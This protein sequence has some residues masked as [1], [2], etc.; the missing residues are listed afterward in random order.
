MAAHE[1]AILA[2]F[3]RLC[4][5]KGLLQVCDDVKDGDRADGIADET[6]LR[7]FL[8]ARRMDLPSALGQFEEAIQFRREKDALRV[9]DRISVDDFEHTRKLVGNPEICSLCRD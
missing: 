1:T 2:Q 9:Y 7:R 6:T 4:L 8:Q 3:S 5:D